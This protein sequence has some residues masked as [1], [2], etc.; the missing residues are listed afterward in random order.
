MMIFFIYNYEQEERRENEAEGEDD[1]TEI[2]LYW[3]RIGWDSR[4]DTW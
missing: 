1:T 3:V 2:L 4:N